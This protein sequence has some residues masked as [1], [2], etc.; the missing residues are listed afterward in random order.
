MYM[1]NSVRCSHV[2]WINIWKQVWQ[3]VSAVSSISSRRRSIGR[4]LRCHGIV[5]TTVPVNCPVIALHQFPQCFAQVDEARHKHFTANA[6]QHIIKTW[7][8]HTHAGYITLQR[9][10]SS[11]SSSSSTNF[12]ATQVLQKLQGR[13]SFWRSQWLMGS[14]HGEA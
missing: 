3:T 9:S 4:C 14:L 2:K 12:I 5:M 8:L 6:L 7:H 10:S 11:S 13:W 1:C